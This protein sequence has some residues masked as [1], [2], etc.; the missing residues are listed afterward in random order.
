MRSLLFLTLL[1]PPALAQDVA[2]WSLGDDPGDQFGASVAACGDVDADGYPDWIVGAPKA[3]ANGPNSGSA[4]VYSG[5]TGALLHRFDGET[6][7]I[8][9]GTSVDG[10]GDVNGDGHADLIVGAPRASS[11]TLL[12]GVV[13]V[14]SGADWSEIHRI[15]G[16][17]QFGFHGQVVAGAGD[18]DGDGKSDF[19]IATPYADANGV[20]SG[21]VTL[22]SGATGLFIRSHAGD[23]ANAHFG[24][25]LDGGADVDGDGRADYVIG[26]PDDS[27]GG[28]GAGQAKVLSGATGLALGFGTGAAG[29]RLGAAVALLGDLDANGRSE[30]AFGAPGAGA[31]DGFVL[32]RRDDDTLLFL[33]T[34][35]TG[36]AFGSALAGAG[37]PHGDGSR[38]VLVGAPL[39]A[40][41][42]RVVLFD[43]T[44]TTLGDLPR[45]THA[46]RFGTSLAGAIDTNGDG[47]DELLVGDPRDDEASSDAGRATLYSTA[48]LAGDRLCDGQ[49]GPCPCGNQAAAGE[50]C[51]NSTGRGAT[52]ETTGT[53]SVALDVLQIGATGLRPSNPA[54]LFTGTNLVDGGSGVPF[55]DGL[56]CTNGQSLRMGVRFADSS[57]AAD[58]GPG[59]AAEGQ[60]DA[61]LVRYFQV[62]YRDPGGSVC[63]SGSNT[64]VALRIQFSE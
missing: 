44:G 33:R 12:S 19:L 2:L 48:M 16:A 26:A 46:D 9:L 42:G 51:L 61:G 37:D 58:W 15:T 52:L 59:L 64:S 14:Y 21:E 38:Q 63:G 8:E 23:T 53:A 5:L 1:S 60:F 45:P 25:A 49:N 56:L 40:G 7:G 3:N 13:I 20:D 11:T 55:K 35:T 43:H 24:L 18:T 17:H 50:G 22:Y 10:A 28:A 47:R 27:L 32:A 29:D 31:G 62:W 30:F 4:L 6:A 57:G 41:G 36:E 54:V 34:G 39:A